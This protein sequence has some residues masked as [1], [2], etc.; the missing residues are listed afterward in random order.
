MIKI[1]IKVSF[2]LIHIP[3]SCGVLLLYVKSYSNG[4]ISIKLKWFIWSM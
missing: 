1:S 3:S 4:W 2:F